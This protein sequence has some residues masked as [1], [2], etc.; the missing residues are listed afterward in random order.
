MNS[1]DAEGQG[2]FWHASVH[3]VNGH[4]TWLSDWMYAGSKA[5][6]IDIWV[7]LEDFSGGSAGKSGD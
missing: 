5:T 4:F 2:G 7:R 3:G 6:I 1:G